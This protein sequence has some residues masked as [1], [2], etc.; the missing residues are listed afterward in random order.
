VRDG[1]L[2]TLEASP[3]YILYPAAPRRAADLVPEAKIIVLLRNPVDRA[4][5]HHG[6]AVRLGFES[7]SFEEAIDAEP[8]RLGSDLEGLEKDPD[9]FSRSF[10]H[11][12]YV[13]RG[14]YAEQ[15]RR[16]FEWFPRENFLFIKR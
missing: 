4:F 8:S 10:H 13:T 15:L 7:L 12:S 5:S 6:Q 3:D 2:L 14:R 9:F 11:F 16:W 1:H